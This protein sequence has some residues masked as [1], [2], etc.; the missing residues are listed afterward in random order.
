MCQ[1]VCVCVCVCMRVCI[2]TQS[3][4]CVTFQAVLEVCELRLT[5]RECEESA[6]MRRP[7]LF[8]DTV[9]KRSCVC[10]CLCGGERESHAAVTSW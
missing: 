10:V 1:T 8:T 7:L 9:V 6:A 3:H 2:H 5:E 4:E